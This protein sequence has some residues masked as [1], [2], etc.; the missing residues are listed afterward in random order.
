MAAVCPHC[1]QSIAH[2]RL[3]V[4][5]TPLKAAIVDA[6]KRH[7]DLGISSAELIGG[8]VYSGRR[9]VCDSAIKA[10][11]GQVNDMLDGSGWRIASDR[12]RW[13]LQRRKIGGGGVV[14]M[15]LLVGSAR[16]NEMRD[17][18]NGGQTWR[19]IVP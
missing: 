13:F 2:E 8:E 3:G 7:G 1:G 15:F 12:R 9:K 11:V 5:L 16:I 17:N 18:T 4:V 6:I 14:A 10:H 19:L